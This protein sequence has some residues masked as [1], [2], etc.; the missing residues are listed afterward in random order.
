M[1]D[2]QTMKAKKLMV[3]T[4]ENETIDGTEFR[5][6]LIH[7]VENEGDKTTVYVDASSNAVTKVEQVIPA[8]NNAV[9]TMEL[10][11]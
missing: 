6:I 7:D 1:P 9:M 5:V 2:M 11:K 8:M 4:L 3:K 10:E